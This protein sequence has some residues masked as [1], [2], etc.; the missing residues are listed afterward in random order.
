M[1]MYIFTGGYNVHLTS[2]RG[3]MA[4]NK[5]LSS[6]WALLTTG[7]QWSIKLPPNVATFGNVGWKLSVCWVR[8]WYKDTNILC[9]IPQRV[10]HGARPRMLVF[11]S[12][13][14]FVPQLP[15]VVRLSKWYIVFSKLFSVGLHEGE[16]I[17][18]HIVP[19]WT[20][21]QRVNVCN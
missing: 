5:L 11:M 21:F 1:S 20:S 13:W 14:I 17:Y 12:T 8:F 6:P 3:L 4:L 15:Q 19:Y 2:V 9:Y 16:S 18:I 10:S 7:H